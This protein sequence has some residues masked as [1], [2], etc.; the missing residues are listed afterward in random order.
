MIRRFLKSLEHG[1]KWL[2]FAIWQL[3]LKKGR[4]SFD[5]VDPTKI[6]R[7]LLIRPDRLG[8][9]VVSLP[10]FH[11]LKKLYPHLQLYLISSPRN[12]VVVRD[13]ENITE[14]FLY[15][16]HIFKDIATVRKIRRLDVDAIVDLIC[17]DSV[18]TLLL[19]QYCSGRAWRIGRDKNRHGRFY[20]FNY[21]YKPDDKTHIL[22]CT[23]KL[24][25]AFG[26]DTDHAETYVPP[27]IKKEHFDK[28]DKFLESLD[29]N[30]AGAVIGLNIS[31]GRPTRVWPHENNIELL[32]RLLKMYPSNHFV[33]SSDP[34]ERKRAVAL[35]GKFSSRVDPLPEG[36][37]LLEVSAIISR[38]KMLITPDTSLVHIARSFNIPTVSLIPHYRKSLTTWPPY[39][40]KNG[41]VASEN[42]YNIFDIKVDKVLET[43]KNILAPGDTI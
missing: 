11:N 2:F 38:L 28:A 25:S 34:S 41:A 17:D 3:F 19:S 31:A 7:V 5:I 13:D 10:V 37:S 26:I 15:T 14:N 4:D 1:F 39:N 9:M 36:I 22:D 32:E 40:Q 35:A 42:D 12:V 43:V 30:P 21:H 16:K 33:I 23:L 27:T 20:D 29:G 6:K 24:L 18:T 8:D